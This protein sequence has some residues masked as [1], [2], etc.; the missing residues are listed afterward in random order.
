M[1]TGNEDDWE[2]TQGQTTNMM[3]R[4]SQD[5]HVKKRTLLGKV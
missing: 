3:T 5:K 4:P 1:I 2:K